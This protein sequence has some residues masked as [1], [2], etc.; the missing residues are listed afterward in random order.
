M[1]SPDGTAGP[2]VVVAAGATVVD[3]PE[4]V[5]V[6]VGLAVEA[7]EVPWEASFLVPEGPTEA[8]AVARRSSWVAPTL[9]RRERKRLRSVPVATVCGSVMLQLSKRPSCDS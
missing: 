1:R 7:W 6:A 8:G 9:G 5:V 3:G 2:V 4:A